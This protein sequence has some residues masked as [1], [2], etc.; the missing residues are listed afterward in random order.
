MRAAELAGKSFLFAMFHGG[1]NLPLIL[2][3][4]RKL[5][6][7][8]HRV[9]VLAGPRIWVPRPPPPTA[10]LDAAIE[11]GATVLLLPVPVENPHATSPARRGLLLGWTPG[12]LSRA[13]N[14]GTAS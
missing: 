8:G 13:R 11:A 10:L 3:V 5:T 6:S 14:L 2:P 1:G 4:V 12:R 9:R 7:R